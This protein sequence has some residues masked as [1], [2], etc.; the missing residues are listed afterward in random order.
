MIY[1][2]GCGK[3]EHPNLNIIGKRA[4]F[5]SERLIVEC[6]NRIRPEL[7]QELCDPSSAGSVEVFHTNNWQGIRRTGERGGHWE[8]DLPTAIAHQYLNQAEDRLKKSGWDFSPEKTKILMLTHNVLAS[9]QGYSNIVSAFSS[10]D[11]YIKKEDD[12]IAFFVDVV[13]PICLSYQDHRFG[14]MFA[15][16]G[17]RTPSITKQLDKIKW[18]EDMNALISLRKKGTINDIIELLKKTQ[19]PR[20]S[21]KIENKEKRI[22]HLITIQQSELPNE[23]ATFLDNI[24]K[25]KEVSYNEVI[26]LSKFI[27]NKTPFA[28][29]HGVKGAE[30]ENVLVVCGRGWN[31]YNFNQMLEWVTTGIPS[32][33]HDTFE[34]NRNLFYVACSRPKKRLAILFTQKI[35]SI[36][37][38]TL[39]YWFGNDSIIAL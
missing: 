32:D 1:G 27:Q 6:L 30:F 14:E 15:L 22:N 17:N 25:F 13:E 4:N 8:G 20:L 38:G 23:D 5:R 19:R 29:N 35:S 31:R 18:A 2:N 12:Y 37:M 33:K 10:T 9:E 3:I 36:A 16:L 21:E 39:T 28:T 34:R 24:K 26:E 11:Y 7:T